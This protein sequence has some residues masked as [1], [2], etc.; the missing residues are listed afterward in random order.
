MTHGI[1]PVYKRVNSAI[2]KCKQQRGARG[3]SAG[4]DYSVSTH[5][6]HSLQPHRCSRRGLR[7]QARRTDDKVSGKWEDGALLH[8]LSL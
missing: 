6:P 3:A 1:A 5:A 4:R 7:S 2:A 8:L